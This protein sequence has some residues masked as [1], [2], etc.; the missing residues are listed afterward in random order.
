MGRR[1][2]GDPWPVRRDGHA[3]KTR[4]RHNGEGITV[5]AFGTWELS[6]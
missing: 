6:V 1:E 3:R 2:L 5:K 4:Y